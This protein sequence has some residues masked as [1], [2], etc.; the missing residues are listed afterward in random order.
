[1]GTG[2]LS[3]LTEMFQN[4]IKKVAD[5][6]VNILYVTEMANFILYEFQFSKLRGK[7]KGQTGYLA[8]CKHQGNIAA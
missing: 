4:Y 2:F 1:M 6:T 3:G 8:S 5:N 7:K